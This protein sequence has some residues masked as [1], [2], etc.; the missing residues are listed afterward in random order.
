MTTPKGHIQAFPGTPGHTT[1]STCGMDV[2]NFTTQDADAVRV[3]LAKHG[4]GEKYSV[5][6]GVQDTD[7]FYGIVPVGAGTGEDDDILMILNG[8][9]E[10]FA[11]FDDD[12]VPGAFILELC[13]LLAD[14]SVRGYGGS[15]ID[16]M[17]DLARKGLAITAETSPTWGDY[18]WL[19]KR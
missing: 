1:I 10:T 19:L 16:Y 3:M 15:T 18:A 5:M 12:I 11:S 7:R 8:D 4:L 13:H 14:I 2:D 9:D 6:L 17:V